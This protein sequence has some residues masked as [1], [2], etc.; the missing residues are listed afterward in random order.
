MNDPF[1]VPE[2]S[3]D[4]L[5]AHMEWVRITFIDLYQ[6]AETL[7]RVVATAHGVHDDGTSTLEIHVD[8]ET[9]LT[10]VAT[11]DK[12]RPALPTTQLSEAD[13]RR[14]ADA[15]MGPQQSTSA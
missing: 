5:Q 12:P 11:A 10:A 9:W 1:G 14:L 13:A 8:R 6:R 3:Q 7:E 4:L 2:M 15:V